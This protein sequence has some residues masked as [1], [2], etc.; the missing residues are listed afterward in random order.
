MFVVV[1][2][3]E[4]LTK[5][6]AIFEPAEAIGKV[7]AIYHLTGPRNFVIFQLQS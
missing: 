5:G 3:K 2:R 1:P 7:G 6:A 4:V